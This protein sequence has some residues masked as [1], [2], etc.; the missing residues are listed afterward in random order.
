[1]K[2]ML[3]ALLLLAAVILIY[4]STVGGDEGMETKVR[5]GG[6][7]IHAAVERLNP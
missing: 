3:A 7:R 6:G 4:T 1:M 5:N 2:E